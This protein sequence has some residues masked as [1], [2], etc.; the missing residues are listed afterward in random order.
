MDSRLHGSRSVLNR[1]ADILFIQAV[2]AFL[3]MGELTHAGWL[4]GLSDGHVARALALIH[5]HYAKPWTLERLAREIGISRTVLAVRFRTLVGA[6]PI[7][8]LTRWRMLQATKLL[9]EP[10]AG[11]ADVAGKVG[12][13]S[14]A[15]FA[16]A[17]KRT[18]KRTPGQV[19]RSP[20]PP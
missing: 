17:F 7:V 3:S 8:Y 13:T 18:L 6:S 12:Y 20:P 9:R 16:K 5:E 14:E 10:R 4:K 1:L 2:R 19:R 15:A 11:V